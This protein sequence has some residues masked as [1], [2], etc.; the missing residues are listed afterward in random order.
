V[1]K[2]IEVLMEEHRL[3][4]RVLGSLEAY[5]DE[6]RA[7]EPLLRE[8][9]GEF[10]RFFSGFTDAHH[11]AKEEDILFRRMAEQGFPVGAG[12]LAVML[13][14]H[15]LGRAHV[16]AL[17]EFGQGEGR[18]APDEQNL[19]LE[20]AFMYGP[21]LRQHIMKED[22]VLYPMALDLLKEPELDAMNAEFE[23]KDARARADGSYD[24]FHQ[25]ADRLAAR[26]R[27]APSCAM[28]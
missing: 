21:F 3:I 2:T 24:A 23:A 12:P 14:E 28:R 4:E 27:A 10:A 18:L 22:R 6:I 11:H 15:D 5:V 26:Y 17:A 1:H 20:H 25:L 13:H 7:G 9:I 8:A 19:I 16:K